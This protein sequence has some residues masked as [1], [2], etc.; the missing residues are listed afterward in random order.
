MRK[1]YYNLKPCL[2]LWKGGGGEGGLE[3]GLEGGGGIIGD[4]M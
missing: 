4:L 3:V 1:L 2:L